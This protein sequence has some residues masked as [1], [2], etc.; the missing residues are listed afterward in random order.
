MGYM[1]VQGSVPAEY[2]GKWQM[3]STYQKDGSIMNLVQRK[4]RH[5][6]CVHLRFCL[7]QYFPFSNMAL[8]CCWAL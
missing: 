8:G 2:Q 4:V 1:D 3:L 6:F 7:V 5:L